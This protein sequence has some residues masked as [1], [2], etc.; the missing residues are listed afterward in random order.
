MGPFVS[1]TACA[2]VSVYGLY[3]R[4]SL[5]AIWH[6]ALVD[7]DRIQAIWQIHKANIDA[8]ANYMAALKAVRPAS[9]SSAPLLVWILT[10]LA[11]SQAQAEAIAEGRT[12][13][14]KLEPP[15]RRLS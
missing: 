3:V 1:L 12:P 8:G 11:Y 9:T 14:E 6:R 15:P 4:F 10:D 5:C 2:A 13:P 7:R